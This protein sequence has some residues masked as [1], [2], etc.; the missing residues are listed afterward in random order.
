MA[1]RQRGAVRVYARL[2]E[3]PAVIFPYLVHRHVH[4]V[5]VDMEHTAE[6]HR[7]CGARIEVDIGVYERYFEREGAVA[8]T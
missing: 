7:R 2:K 5:A 6:I 4:V 1:H 3:P 8:G